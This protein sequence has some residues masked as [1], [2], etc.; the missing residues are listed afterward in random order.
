MKGFTEVR[1]QAF[2]LEFNSES[3][4]FE[5]KPTAHAFRSRPAPK[6]RVDQVV[7]LRK[8]KPRNE[9]SQTPVGTSPN[10]A[11]KMRDDTGGTRVFSPSD[12]F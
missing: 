4:Q 12:Q 9:V 8:R 7:P 2:K 11:A 10:P 6:L 5:S 3:G 1:G